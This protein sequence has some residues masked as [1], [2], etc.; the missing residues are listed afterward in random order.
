[1]R[2]PVEVT[3]DEAHA[4]IRA[5]ECATDCNWPSVVN[6]FEESGEKPEDLISGWK[7]LEEAA[8]L[9]GTAPSE[10]DF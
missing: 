1:M 4:I 8:G 3:S 2:E 10:E 6:G 9:I 5:L 7:K